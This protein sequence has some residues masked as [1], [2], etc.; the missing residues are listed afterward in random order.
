ME[1]LF[2]LGEMMD[3]PMLLLLLFLGGGGGLAAFMLI[4]SYFTTGDTSDLIW[5]L[6]VLLLQG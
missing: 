3:N 6:V 1:D 2:D 4:G 5:G